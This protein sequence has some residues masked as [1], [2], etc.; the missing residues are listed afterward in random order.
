[1][2]VPLVVYMRILYAPGSMAPLYDLCLQSACIPAGRVLHTDHQEEGDVK[3]AD[4]RSPP[5]TKHEGHVELH[6]EF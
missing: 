2:F 3:H 5:H 1:M 6:T 4:V